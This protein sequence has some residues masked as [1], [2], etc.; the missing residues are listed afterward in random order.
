MEDEKILKLYQSRNEA[1]IVETDRKYGSVAS[2]LRMV[3]EEKSMP[4]MAAMVFEPT[5]SA[6]ST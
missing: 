3:A 5:G 6:V 4:G 2:S 1:A